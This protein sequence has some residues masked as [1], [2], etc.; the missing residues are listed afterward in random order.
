MSFARRK[1][2]GRRAHSMCDGAGEVLRPDIYPP[3]ERARKHLIDFLSNYWSEWP[4]SPVQVMESDVELRKRWPP[5]VQKLPWRRAEQKCS[6]RW[7]PEFVMRAARLNLYEATIL[8]NHMR[9][10]IG[11]G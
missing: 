1:S 7:R 10:F 6:W 3:D 9:S 4:S 11:R 2:Y 8:P 5:L